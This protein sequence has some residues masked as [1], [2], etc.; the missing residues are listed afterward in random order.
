M[1]DR[2]IEKME[3]GAIAVAQ[4]GNTTVLEQV[5]SYDYTSL[6]FSINNSGANALDAFAMQLKG[7]PDDDWHTVCTLWDG[8]ETHQK[9]VSGVLKTCAAATKHIGQVYVY[10][11]YAVKFLASGNGGATTLTLEGAAFR[12]V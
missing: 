10:G 9:Y 8:T 2:A 4:A 3:S 6:C 7:S 11:A 1:A 12:W 5:L